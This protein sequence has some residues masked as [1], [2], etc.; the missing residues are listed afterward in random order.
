MDHTF[1]VAGLGNPGE[2]YHRSP[3]NA[4]FEVV[5]RARALCKGPRFAVRGEAAISECRWRGHGF[6]LLKPLTYMNRSGVEVERWLR[7]TGLPLDRLVVCFDDLDLPFG[8]VRLRPSGGAGGHH[9]MESIQEHL[10]SGEYPRIRIGIK[11]PA[12]PKEENVDYLLTPLP[13]ERWGELEAAAEAAAKALLDAVAHGFTAAMN[14]HN[15]KVKGEASRS[16]G[17]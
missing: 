8:Q 13:E 17:E 4:G 11:D 6:L 7:K 10:G 2:E 9:G 16:E 14:R 5:E 15:R 12:V 3:H 1:L